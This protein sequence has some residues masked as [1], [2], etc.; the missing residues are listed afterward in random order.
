MNVRVVLGVVVAASLN[1]VV[2]AQGVPPSPS[3][4]VK[5]A[6][7]AAPQAPTFGEV[8]PMSEALRASITKVVLM[9]GGKSDERRDRR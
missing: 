6:T 3:E 8:I 1:G 7:A 5:A 4:T 9:P 2:Q